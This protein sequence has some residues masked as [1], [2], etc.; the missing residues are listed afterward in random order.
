[1]TW[2]TGK[3][4]VV[5]LG[6]DDVVELTGFDIEETSAVVSKTAAGDS[7]T[8]KDGTFLDWKGNISFNL[9]HSGT[10][11]SVRAGDVVAFK[12]YTE[13]D[14]TGKTYYSGNILITSHK[15]DSPH[16]GTVTRTMAFEGKGQLSKA[17]V[18]A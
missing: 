14:A 3:N 8:D 17:T 1:M 10:G 15:I 18:S 9:D 2:H 16:D 12:G 7:W 11:Q 6:T 4:G 13:G 5:T